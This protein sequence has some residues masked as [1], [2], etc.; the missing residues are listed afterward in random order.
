MPAA[1][2]GRVELAGELVGRVR[3]PAARHHHARLTAQA[4]IA[5]ASGDLDQAARAYRQAAA[6][7]TEYGH[8]FERGRALLGLGRCLL[9]QHRPEAEHHLQ[10]AQ[11]VFSWL[12]A[13]PVLAETE[14]PG[15][16]LTERH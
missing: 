13:R 5:E 7:W 3:L 12:D 16:H 1:P 8:P 4:V 2:T 10:Q 15:E 11:E 6:R 14:H 9:R